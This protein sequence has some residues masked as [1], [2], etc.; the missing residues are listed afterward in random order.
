MFRY[1]WYTVHR[2]CTSYS[3]LPED[4]PSGSKHV[5]V[6]DT[7]KIKIKLSLTNVHFLCLYYMITLQYTVQ[8]TYNLRCDLTPRSF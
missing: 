4:D 3:R 6:E 5:H 2:A 8:E 7:V 1:I